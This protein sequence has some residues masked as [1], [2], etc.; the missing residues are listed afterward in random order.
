M[1]NTLFF[2]LIFPVF[3]FSQSVSKDS[4]IK[5]Y[6]TNNLNQDVLIKLGEEFAA[7][8]DWEKAIYY[9]DKLVKIDPENPDYLYR[10][11]GTQAAYSEVVNK[12][13]V[14]SIIN[15]AKKNLIKSAS[16]DIN[17][18]YSRWALVQILTELP[19]FLGGN[20]TTALDYSKEIYNISK[21]HGL[22]AYYYIYNFQKNEGLILDT[23]VKIFTEIQSNPILFEFNHFNFVIGKLL[24]NT[25]TSQ[26]NLALRYLNRYLL[27]YSSADRFSLEEV[28]YYLAYC[29]FYLG[30][31]NSLTHLKKS[32]KIALKSQK[33]NYNLISKIE[34][35]N[36][37]INL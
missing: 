3:M 11:G 13:R 6:K 27:N 10:L 22:L 21:I 30:N 1:N 29:N 20:K 24:I 17:H 7:E 37:L 8:K 9:Y 32:R 34:E 25:D 2:L 35:L 5:I 16:L 12:F 4:L 26:F 15:T 14:L 31:N 23:E 28:Y 18:I 36:K 33:K 19:K